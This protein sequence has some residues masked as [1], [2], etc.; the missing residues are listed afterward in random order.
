MGCE[1]D[2]NMSL[3]NV[4]G[5]GWA[6]DASDWEG[7]EP[8]PAGSPARLAGVVTACKGCCN[9]YS[10][11]IGWYTGYR[12]QECVDDCDKNHGRCW[13]GCKPAK[14]GNRPP[15]VGLPGDGGRPEV[16]IPEDWM[17]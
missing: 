11:P 2:T 5:M 8:P 9:L 12:Y 1:G 10:G 14:K 6:S 15:G 17:W 7:C 4:G 13:P 16:T 3:L